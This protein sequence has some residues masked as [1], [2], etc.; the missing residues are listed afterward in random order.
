MKTI[1]LCELFMVT[2]LL[3]TSRHG[4]LCDC[5]G[6]FAFNAWNFWRRSVTSDTPTENK[7]LV[8]IAMM[9]TNKHFIVIRTH[10]NESVWKQLS[11]RLLAV[12][13]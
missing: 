13:I 7:L 5:V 8:L 2:T 10:K 11:V 9:K 1:E 4:F 3:L 12:N 6:I